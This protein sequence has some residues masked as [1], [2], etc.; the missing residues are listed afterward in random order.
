MGSVVALETL[1]ETLLIGR[2]DS[3]KSCSISASGVSFGI[4]CVVQHTMDPIC[5]VTESFERRSPCGCNVTSR[6]SFSLQTRS[7]SSGAIPGLETS[8]RLHTFL[9]LWVS[10][11]R[12]LPGVGQLCFLARHRRLQGLPSL[13]RLILLPFTLL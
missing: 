7:S 12:R 8:S 6:H 10:T 5:F 13:R 1:L 3:L 2:T 9:V 4:S 11:S